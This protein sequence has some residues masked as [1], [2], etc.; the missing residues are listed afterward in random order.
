MLTEQQLQDFS[1]REAEKLI[2]LYGEAEKDI[3]KIIAKGLLK[4][5]DLTYQKTVLANVKAIL[6]DLNKGARTWT[7]AS[8]KSTYKNAAENVDDNLKE[9]GVFKP[10]IGFGAIHQQA[11]KVLAD[12]AF[13]RLE[14]VSQVI[15]RQSSDLY[16]NAALDAVRGAVGG[17]ETWQQVARRYKEQLA[18]RGITGFKDKAGRDWDMTRYARVVAR[19]TTMECHIQGS[20]N[21][22]LEQGHDLIKISTHRNAC[23]KC[24]PWQGKTLSLTGQ[25]EGYQTLDAAKA[26]GLFHPNCRHALSISLDLDAEIAKLEKKE[27]NPDATKKESMK[28]EE[29]IEQSIQSAEEKT[30]MVNYKWAK[31]YYELGTR[32]SGQDMTLKNA[33]DAAYED[34]VWGETTDWEA[35]AAFRAGLKGLDFEI[36][37]WKRYGPVPVDPLTGFA[38]KSRNFADGELEYGVSTATEEWEN[39]LRGKISD[40]RRKRKPVYF[41]GLQVGWGSDG[42]A[43]VLPIKTRSIPPEILKRT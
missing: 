42:E 28:N 25:T 27:I 17:Y 9:L 3:L 24:V 8:V 20:C 1:D 15:G 40:A 33:I 5:N 37:V 4:G 12:N 36:K 31:K 11:M 26:A 43:V 13:D 21:R 7:N 2:R 16:R 30:K 39:S 18:D 32:Y 6:A 34:G 22:L 41:R 14:S 10:S 23:D 19:T 29:K 38:A 35:A